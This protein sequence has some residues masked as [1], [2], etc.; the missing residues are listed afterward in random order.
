MN[1]NDEFPTGWKYPEYSLREVMEK[2]PDY[3][4][5]LLENAKISISEEAEDYWQSIKHSGY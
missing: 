5:W 4:I 1:L 3:V 2:D